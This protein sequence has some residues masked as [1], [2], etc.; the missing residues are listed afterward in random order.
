MSPEFSPLRQVSEA[1]TRGS[2]LLFF[3]LTHAPDREA[4]QP[5][6]HT[7][8]RGACGSAANPDSDR[9]PLPV[10]F[11]TNAAIALAFFL[12]SATALGASSVYRRFFKRIKNAEWITPELLGGK[13]WI[14]GIVTRCVHHLSRSIPYSSLSAL[15]LRFF[16]CAA[17]VMRITSAFTTH[18]ALAG[19]AYSSLGMCLPRIEVRDHLT[20]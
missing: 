13:R 20:L 12:G 3:P 15:A 17:W 6:G 9:S 5:G 10:E 16:R 14:T 18:L 2:L 11:D 7:T 4:Q 1:F 19:A 8:P